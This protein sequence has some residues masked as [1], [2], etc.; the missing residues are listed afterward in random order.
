MRPDH[1]CC[2]PAGPGSLEPDCDRQIALL[3][4]CARRAGCGWVVVNAGSCLVGGG[5]LVAHLGQSGA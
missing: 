5:C 4:A 2:P 3:P 1:P